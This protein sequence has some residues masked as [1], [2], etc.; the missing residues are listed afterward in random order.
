MSEQ[1]RGEQAPG[2][3]NGAA[4]APELAVEL[5]ADRVATMEI[6]RPPSNY[7]SLDLIAQIADA[8]EE[9]AAGG[10][11]RAIVLCSAGRIFCAGAD[12]A[13]GPQLSGEDGLHLYDVAARLFEQPLP[14]VAAVQGAAIG[15]GLGLAMAADFRVASPDARFA[16]NFALLGIHQ[17]FA[18]SVTLPAAIGQQAALELLYTGRR[19]TGEEAVALGLADRLARPAEARAEARALAASIAASAPLAVRSIRETM[20]GPLAKQ[21]RQAMA[22]ERAEQERLMQTADWREGLA[23]VRDRRPANFTGQ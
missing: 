13:A 4:P 7:F 19:V 22:R 16:A 15:G 6:N 21:A 14:I 3:Q 17:G 20:R 23:A 8:C 12:F 11:C 2:E 10:D 18:L 1:A 9:L 5:A